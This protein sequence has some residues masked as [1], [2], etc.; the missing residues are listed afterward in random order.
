MPSSPFSRREGTPNPAGSGGRGG[1]EG[2]REELGILSRCQLLT[3]LQ[4]CALAHSNDSSS[5]VQ[6]LCQPTCPRDH[7]CSA[8]FRI[9]NKTLEPHCL[10]LVL[11]APCPV[12]EHSM[13][14]GF[15]KSHS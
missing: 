10:D 6:G 3:F 14:F 8:W 11:M 4:E 15:L 7:I 13:C 12:L 2:K 1:L 9:E 5:I